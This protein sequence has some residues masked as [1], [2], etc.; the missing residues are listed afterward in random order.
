MQIPE[1]S[2][3]RAEITR[4]RNQLRSGLLRAQAAAGA[5][6]RELLSWVAS[7]DSAQ[8]WR[9][10]GCRHMAEW[11]S[12]HL[13]ISNWKARRFIDA[14]HKLEDLP[15]VAAALE[16]GALSLDKTVELTRFATPDDERKLLRW[17]RGVTVARIRER[18]DELART[19]ERDVK[20]AHSARSLWWIWSAN[21][22]R[23]DVQG[24]LAGETA[25]AFV[26][27]IDSAAKELPDTFAAEEGT[28]EPL[29][30]LAADQ[31]L[32]QRRAD[33]L[34]LLVTSQGDG[35][36]KQPEIVI[37]APLEALASG[38]GTCSVNGR[39]ALHPSVVNRLSCDARLR[40]V[41]TDEEGDPLGIGHASQIAP[42]WMRQEVFRR[43]GYRCTFPGCEMRRWLIP[44]HI[45][46]WVH[47]GPTH[48]DNLVTVCGSHHALVHHFDW[49]VTLEEGRVIWRAP[50]GKT[51][52]PGPA[53]PERPPEQP[54]KRRRAAEVAGY[55]RIFDVLKVL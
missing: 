1:V 35:R 47:H 55:H 18:G 2:Q 41:L 33:A 44:H 42:G 23:L 5:A 49:G 26:E 20:D 13:H 4:D 30:G 54:L 38:D 43:D 52:D 7:C 15:H 37:H 16:T 45:D 53:P 22:D 36:P 29:D 50:L 31:G 9:D 46:H 48:P 8:L 25:H 19:D 17:A 28:T 39:P 40:F 34:A 24:V 14:A 10:N 11:L 21:R 12:G 3:V 32:D 27:A 51:Y 6:D